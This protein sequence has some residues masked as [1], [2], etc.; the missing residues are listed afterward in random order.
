[1]NVS[2]VMTGMPAS[3]AFFSGWTIWVLSVG[4]T[5]MASG[6]RAITASSTGV[7]VTGLKSGAPWKMRSAPTALAAA[8]A[9][10]R[11]VM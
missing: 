5:R 6:W 9:P 2:T 1:M 10:L 4:A 3:A 8:S 7:C 11:I